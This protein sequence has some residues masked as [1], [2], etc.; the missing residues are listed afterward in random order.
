[1]FR[2]I[3]VNRSGSMASRTDR[4]LILGTAGHIDHGKTS[5]VL[6]LTGTDTDRLPDEKRRGITIDLGFAELRS[7]NLQIGIVDVPGHERFIRNMLAGASGF[8]MAL[9]VV[10]ADD[11]IMPQTREHFEILKILGIKKGLIVLTKADLANE[12]WLG[13]VEADIRELVEGSFLE[14]SPII[15]ASARLGTGIAE[16]RQAIFQIAADLEMADRSGP[17]RLSIDRAFNREGR[18]AV[19]TGSVVSGS[20]QI[21]DI[22][23]ISPSGLTVRARS[24]QSHGN[25]ISDAEK[26]MRLAV[27]LAGVKLEDVARG[28]ELATPGLLQ[29]SRWVA[30][31]LQVLP[32]SPFS[33]RHRGRYRM[34]AGTA[35]VGCTVV[36]NRAESLIQPGE[37]RVVMIR[38]EEPLAVVYGQPFVIRS[39]SPLT[40]MAGGS[41]I[42]PSARWIRRRDAESWELVEKLASESPE[43]RL[44]A[45]MALTGTTSNDDLTL[46]REL[47]M[48]HSQQEQLV[49]TFLL[50]GELIELENQRSG[51]KSVIPRCVVEKTRR[52]IQ[53]KLR[54]F[55]ARFP[56]LTGMIQVAL[57]QQ[58]SDLPPEL[59]N[60]IIAMDLADHQIR[61]NGNLLAMHDHRPQLTQ[62]EKR[63]REKLFSDLTLAGLQPPFLDDWVRQ[64]GEKPELL[65]DILRVLCAEKQVEEISGGMFLGKETARDII[66]K[67]RQWFELNEALTVSELRG[68]LDV[69]RKQAV[70]I[71]EWLDRRHVTVR[72]G[73]IRRLV[74][75][76]TET[77]S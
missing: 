27:N 41:V 15:R 40:T 24:L 33:I 18:G 4:K 61:K 68:L 36:T 37:T 47:G 29:A 57:V 73:D 50:N 48:N 31:Q 7:E 32:S 72:T 2:P 77:E 19:V 54:G 44:M 14:N 55:H 30:V 63:L 16:L 35:E 51:T 39:E 59:V 17:F 69:S 26:G 45:W 65:L 38:T 53:R 76:Q 42:W 46:F 20:L 64:T 28:S 58:I 25:S 22:L 13:L 66:R 56:R 67:V 12:E 21:G 3:E 10:A 60:Q 8:D 1:M 75:H 49:K 23:Q 70:P 74:G 34:H 62:S 11:G 71:A 6:A 5:L 52:R 9:L 43:I